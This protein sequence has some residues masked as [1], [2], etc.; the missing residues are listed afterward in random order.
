MIIKIQRRIIPY[1]NPWNISFGPFEVKIDL[2]SNGFE[3]ILQNLL[4]TFFFLTLYVLGKN[5]LYHVIPNA[6]RVLKMYILSMLEM[7]KVKTNLGTLENHKSVLVNNR[8]SED[9]VVKW[10]SLLIQ[11][12]L[13][14]WAVLIFNP[15]QVY[16]LCSPHPGKWIGF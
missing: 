3:N 1:F 5:G 6:N 11:V 2:R 9:F 13:Q 14:P 7:L 16:T 12:V 8:Y 10:L 4:S 15:K